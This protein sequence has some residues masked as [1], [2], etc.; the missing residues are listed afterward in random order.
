[1][2]SRSRRQRLRL[3]TFVDLPE[4]LEG[5]LLTGQQLLVERLE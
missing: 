1:M 3:E 2:F 5:S 4:E